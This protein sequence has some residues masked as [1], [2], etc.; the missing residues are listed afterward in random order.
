MNPLI[1]QIIKATNMHAF[2]VIRV[3]IGTI[4]QTPFQVENEQKAQWLRMYISPC[5]TILDL[6]HTADI[7][8][9]AC[10]QQKTFYYRGSVH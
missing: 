1:T 5:L 3:Q 7:Q 8:F 10:N 2:C 6:D 4:L 9:H